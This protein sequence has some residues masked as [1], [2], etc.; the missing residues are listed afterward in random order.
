[1]KYVVLIVLA[2]AVCVGCWTE[3]EI[4]MKNDTGSNTDTDTDADTDTDSDT[5]TDTDTDID[6]DTDT[7]TDAIDCDELPDHCCA[8]NC[9][10]DDDADVCVP[11]HWSGEDGTGV[12]QLPAEPGECWTSQECETGE[13][14]AG[15]FVCG[16]E[17]LCEW[18]GPGICAQAA[19]GCCGGD[20]D[21]AENYF[22]MDMDPDPDDTCHGVLEFPACWTDTDCTGGTCIDAWPCSCNA[23]C[24]G[25]P[26]L[27]DNWS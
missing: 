1:M 27:C 11:T 15:V 25:E 21:C 17:M 24:I 4:I 6:T 16:C 14:C 23:Y 13:F 22:C 7:D 5:D 3:Q 2:G 20:I 9:P 10:C 8:P 19:T 12:C 26:G 18:E